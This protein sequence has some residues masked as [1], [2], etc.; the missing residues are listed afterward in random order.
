MRP[1]ALCCALLLGAALP[2]FAAAAP[3][4]KKTQAAAKKAK[5]KAFPAIKGW[6]KQGKPTFYGR[7]TVW[8]AINGAAELFVSYGF[9][10]LREQGYARKNGSLTVQLYDQGA[11]LGAFG[12]FARERPPEGKR[13]AAAT[14]AAYSA[15]AHCLGYKGRSYLKVVLNTGKLSRRSCSHLLATL[16]AWLPGSHKP[17]RALALLPEKGRVPGSARYTRRSFLGTKRLRNCVHADYARGP[18]VKKRYTLFVMLP[19]KGESA[20]AAW[21]RLA[22]HWK[23]VD[24]GGQ[25]LLT[26]QIPYRGTVA[27]AEREGLLVGASGVGDLTATAA[28]LKNLGKER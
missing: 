6:R 25:K 18:D 12:V 17:P 2:S 5:P 26:T 1:L 28:L 24:V 16:A 22:A 14:D 3:A 9:I 23:A 10:S 13:L 8:Q 19:K 11:P 21:K 15:G 20:M 7:D 27:L 4:A